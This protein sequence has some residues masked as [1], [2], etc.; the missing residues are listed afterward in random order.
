MRVRRTR[1]TKQKHPDLREPPS[2][3]IATG[4]F[5]PYG[6]VPTPIPVDITADDVESVATRLSGAAG[7]GGTDAVDLRNWLLRFGKESEALRVEMALWAAWLANGTPPWAAI[8]TLMAARLV[9][10]AK[11]PGVR[12][13]GIGEIYRRLFAKCLL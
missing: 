6:A 4:A 7:P 13:V 11:E 2:V 3:G 10:L 8:R 1:E 12:L 9:A 5:E